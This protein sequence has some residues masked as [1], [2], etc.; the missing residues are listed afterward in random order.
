MSDPGIILQAGNIQGPNPNNLI[1]MFEL[2][3]QVQQ[4]KLQTAKRNTLLQTFS[5]PNSVDPATGTPTP[6]AIRKVMSVDPEM[7]LKLQDDA[8][9]AQVKR[10]QAAHYKTVAGKS[11][12]DFMSQV[13][14]VGYDAYDDAKKAGKSESDAIAAGQAARNEAVKN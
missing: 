1:S 14:G 7:G 4:A 12:F 9:D 8:L 10:A 2:A 5:D 13:A 3:Q 11:N 6:Q